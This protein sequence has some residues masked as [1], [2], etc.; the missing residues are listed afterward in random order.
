[1]TAQLEDLLAEVAR[2][3]ELLRAAGRSG[4]S[5]DYTEPMD[6]AGVRTEAV[7]AL[8]T[9]IRHYADG[10]EATRKAVRASLHRHRTFRDSVYVRLG[11]DVTPAG[12]RFALLSMSAK[13]HGPDTRD[14]LWRLWDIVQ[15]AEAEGV[16]LAPILREV[17]ELSSD[18]DKQGMGSMRQILARQADLEAAR[19]AVPPDR[20]PVRRWLY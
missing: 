13:D 8:R 20:R 5:S 9:L 14:E 19:E 6:R 11:E 10:D 16:P 18:V 3:D 1:M 2:L 7:A 12:F 17:A 15:R 4:A